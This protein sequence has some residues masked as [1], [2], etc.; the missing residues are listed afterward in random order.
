MTVQQYMN[1]YWPLMDEM[2]SDYT[3]PNAD[4][5]MNADH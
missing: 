1:W 5:L 2:V 3:K 4:S